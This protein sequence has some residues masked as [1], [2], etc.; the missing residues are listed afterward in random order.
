MNEQAAQWLADRETG[1]WTAADAARLTAWRSADPRHD[2]AFARAE[3]LWHALDGTMIAPPAMPRRRIATP[4]RIGATVAAALVVVMAVAADLPLRWRADAMTATGEIRRVPLPDGSV[5]T[6]DTAS[7]IAIAADGRTIRL[8]R[9][10]AAFQV[11]ARHGQA[12]RVDAG[13][14]RS[15]ALGT[16]FL[17]A[18]T[19]A[20]A[21]VI[22]TEHRVAVA[23]AGHQVVLS[24]GEAVD[25]DGEGL[26]PPRPVAIA[27]VEAWT[28]RRLRVVDRPL[29]EVVATI[30]RYHRGYLGIAGSAL[31]RRRISGTFDIGDPLRAIDLIERTLAIRSIRLTSHVIILHA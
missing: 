20:G 22:V 24:A 26:G 11:A 29:G 2:R 9:G 15:V 12:F 10:A 30:A 14:G 4:R 28:H 1:S 8:L 7:A 5:A 25:Y 18:R 27:D 13:A 19:A 17:V 21:R 23:I 31:A 16:R 6:L 3:R